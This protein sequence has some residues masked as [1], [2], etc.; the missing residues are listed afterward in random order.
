MGIK[1]GCKNVYLLTGHG[2]KHFDNLEKNN[3][4]PNF[5]AENFLQAA[6]FIMDNTK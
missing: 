4:K 5:I 2:K 1:V 6:E 3:I